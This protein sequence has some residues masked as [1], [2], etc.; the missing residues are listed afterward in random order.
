ML[1]D[2][3]VWLALALAQHEYHRAAAVWLRS[4]P[5]ETRLFM[6]RATQQSLLR[7]LTTRAVF[8]GLATTPLTNAEAL[9][10]YRSLAADD[11]IAFRDEPSGL[12]NLWRAWSSHPQ[13]S[14][15]LWMDAYLAAFARAADLQLVTIDRGFRQFEGLRLTVI[16]RAS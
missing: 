9:D 16:E 11:R 10:F 15:K 14:P 8:E 13:S 5:A 4:L 2:S 1:P 3:N 7:L 12:E 6:C